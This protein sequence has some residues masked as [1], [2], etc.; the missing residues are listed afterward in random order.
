LAATAKSREAATL[1]GSIND[2][3]LMSATINNLAGWEFDDGDA[4]AAEGHWKEAL[5]LAGE[6]P[7]DASGDVDLGRTSRRSLEK[8][9]S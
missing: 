6:K 1:A 9:S 7:D 2:A 4:S 8:W 3:W 5:L